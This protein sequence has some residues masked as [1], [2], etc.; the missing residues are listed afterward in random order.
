MKSYNK[1]EIG[2]IEVP[3]PAGEAVVVKVAGAGICHS[4]LHLL[5]GELP[6]FP[7][8]LPIVL[9]HENSGYVHAIGEKVSSTWLNKPV[10]V[11]GGWY[12]EEDEFTL[13]G[14]QQLADKA[15]WPGILKYHGGY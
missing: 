2:E 1:L 14:D 13:V 6:G 11:F 3:E 7:T 8:P 4:D 10:L 9:G 15:T 12:E 5:K